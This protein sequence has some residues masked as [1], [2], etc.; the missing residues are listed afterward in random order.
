MT[1]GNGDAAGRTPDDATDAG[2][3]ADAD[4]D[5]AHDR[6]RRRTM[7]R[8]AGG[9]AVVGLALALLAG[10][11]GATGQAGAAIFLLTSALGCALGATWGVVAAVRDD[12]RGQRVSRARV[13]WVLGL[14]LGAA[15]LMAMTAGAGG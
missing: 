6:R 15:M 11:A 8:I 4:D 5:L 7:R 3:P 9:G 2:A 1:S 10:L 12:L 13:A 14:F